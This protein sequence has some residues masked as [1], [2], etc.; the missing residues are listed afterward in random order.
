MTHCTLA[1]EGVKKVPGTRHALERLQFHFYNRGSQAFPTLPR[2]SFRMVS[3]EP[4]PGKVIVP[5]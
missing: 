2:L 5:Y 4:W 1:G 3:W